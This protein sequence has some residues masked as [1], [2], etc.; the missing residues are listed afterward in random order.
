MTNDS[1]HDAGRQRIIEILGRHRVDFIVIGGA[2]S[3]SRGWK[4][5][6]QDIDV[7]PARDPAN[8][9]ASRL[10]AHRARRTLPR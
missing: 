6:T 5:R 10:R 1:E 2:A 7:T 8:P 9:H 4:G 3:Q